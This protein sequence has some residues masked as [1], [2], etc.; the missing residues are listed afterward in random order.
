MARKHP[1]FEPKKP[2]LHKDLKFPEG[3]L[4]GTSTSAH[5][6]E[7]WNEYNDWWEWEHQPGTIADG[8]MSGRAADHYH[9]FREDFDIIQ[10]MNN[11]AHRLSIEWSR[12]NPHKGEFNQRVIDHYIE[13]L[14]DLKH[15]KIKTMVTLHHFTIP[16]WFAEIGGFEK[17]EN[18]EYF[19]KFVDH[20]VPQLK[21]YVDFWITINEPNIYTMMSYMLGLWPPGKNNNR[22]AYRVFNNLASAHKLAYESIHNVYPNN[23]AQVGIAHNVISFYTY[24]KHSFSDWLS[25]KIADWIWNHWFMEKTKVYH[26]FLGVNYYVHKRV[27]KIGL[28]NWGDLALEDRGEGRERTDLAWEIFAPGFFDALV[29]MSDYNLPIYITE[30]GISTL[31]D[32]QRARYLISYLKELYHATK[33]GVDVRGYFYWSLLDNFEWDKGITS[34]F[35]LV[36]VNYK[37]LERTVRGSGDLYQI[38]CET[39][40]I[41]H[42]LLQFIGHKVSPEDVVKE[43]KKGH[44]Y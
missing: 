29:D 14:Q 13:V 42:D 2:H 33:S 30:N 3:F 18:V 9:K 17:K 4:W 28:R 41:P 35:G 27:K 6:V 43:F 36:E 24:D 21:D 32:H 34:R 38:I 19:I 12:I 31:N 16:I 11:N 22:L 44:K 10:S 7:G 1:G 26:D 39:N 37:T 5:Q 20:V 15:R 25:V 8:Q 23:V 40:S